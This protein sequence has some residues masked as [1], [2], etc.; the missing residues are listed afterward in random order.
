MTL[1]TNREVWI[2]GVAAV[3]NNKK[4]IRH[5]PMIRECNIETQSYN[6]RE[7]N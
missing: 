5:N 2:L 7:E 4:E 6:V 1:P 3:I